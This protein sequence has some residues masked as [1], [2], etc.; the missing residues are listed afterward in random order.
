MANTLLERFAEAGGVYLLTSDADLWPLNRE[1]Y[2]LTP[3]KSILS[4]NSECCV[5]F[6][7]QGEVFKM[8]PLSNVGMNI[9]M[10]SDTMTKFNLAPS[11]A[12]EILLY[13]LKEFGTIA[14]R[15]VSK[16]ENTGWY[17]DQ[18]TVSMA[19]SRQ[20]HKNNNSIKYVPRNTNVDRIDKHMLGGRVQVE[21]KID[22]HL[23]GQAFRKET[24][25]GVKKVLELMYGKYS[26]SL[27]F[28]T[29][30]FL[31]FRDLMAN[32]KVDK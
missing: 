26:V 12:E 21:D 9:S 27:K 24:F 11:S 15:P 10:W 32:V 16:G 14:S 2:T 17:M 25:Q 5:P 31:V 1:T 13:M 29:E 8:L 3:G 23:P 4:L 30:Y 18:M 22:T 28:C 19:I 7:H 20:H 6:K